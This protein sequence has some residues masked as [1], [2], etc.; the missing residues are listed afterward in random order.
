[1]RIS[2]GS[3]SKTNFEHLKG[4][5]IFLLRKIQFTYKISNKIRVAI[6]GAVELVDLSLD[7]QII[8]FPFRT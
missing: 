8:I 2:S 1:M 3:G 6:T 7:L 5:S 4:V